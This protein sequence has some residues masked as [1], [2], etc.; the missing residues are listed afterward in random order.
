[1]NRLVGTEF[2]GACIC[3]PRLQGEGRECV[4]DVRDVLR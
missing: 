2:F 1:M 3:A 4:R